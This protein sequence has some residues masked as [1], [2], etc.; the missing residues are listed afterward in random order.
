MF[1][2]FRKNMKKVSATMLWA[3]VLAFH[4]AA[5]AQDIWVNRFETNNTSLIARMNQIHD[6]T[7]N[8]C[9]VLR[10]YVRG[11]DYR[12]EPN[13]GVVKDSIID[14]E[15]RIWVSEGTRRLTIRHKDLK[16]LIGYT[17]PIRLEKLKDYDV[18]VESII[19]SHMNGNTNNV[20]ENNIVKRKVKNHPFYLGAGFNAMSIS[21]PS[22]NMGINIKHHTLEIEGVL[23]LNKTGLINNFEYRAN[24]VGFRYGYEVPLFKYLSITPEVGIAYTMLDDEISLADSSRIIGLSLKSSLNGCKLFSVIGGIRLSVPITKR[25][26]LCV[27]PEYNY[28]LFPSKDEEQLIKSEKTLESFFTGFNLNASLVIFL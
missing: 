27:T 10:C 18:D 20:N 7:G 22:L 12:I 3:F 28:G 26:K 16:P 5:N 1:L 6:N 23:G 19:E 15:I 11:N 4:Y 8:A 25:F 13:L 14:G 24:R 21:G 9:A 2:I 17:I